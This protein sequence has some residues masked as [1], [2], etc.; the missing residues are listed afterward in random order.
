MAQ[1]IENI[2]LLITAVKINS[3]NDCM[4]TYEEDNNT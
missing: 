1:G 3:F 4:A 2:Y